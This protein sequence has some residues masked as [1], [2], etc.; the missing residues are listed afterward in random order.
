MPYNY[1]YYFRAQVIAI[2]AINLHEQ[3]HR[4]K[5]SGQCFCCPI[6]VFYHT[7]YP[8]LSLFLLYTINCIRALYTIQCI[9][10]YYLRCIIYCLWYIHHVMHY[11][12]SLQY[13]F[14][15]CPFHFACIYA[16]IIH[17]R[18][19]Y[20]LCVKIAI[21]T[22]VAFLDSVEKSIERRNTICVRRS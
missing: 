13:A 17:Y 11:I 21:E 9:H 16:S 10:F 8:S 2:I 15:F 12:V 19:I 4:R 7:E 3:S 22:I 5:L 18:Y 20:Y 1:H 14:I 6:G